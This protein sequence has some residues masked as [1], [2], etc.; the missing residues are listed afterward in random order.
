M[1]GLTAVQTICRDGEPA[2]ALIPY[3]EYFR[4]LETARRVPE[5]GA[6][7]HEVMRLH[8]V[9]GL[10]LRRACR[11]YLRLIQA[12]MRAGSASANPR[13]RRSSRPRHARGVRR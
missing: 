4:L 11:E 12:R 6:V 10:M 2:F 5:G 13:L 9:D 3:D 7:P 8:A 1:S